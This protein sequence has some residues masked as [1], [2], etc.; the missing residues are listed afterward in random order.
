M[1]AGINN[2]ALFGLPLIHSPLV[3]VLYIGDIGLALL[4]QVC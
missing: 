3:V 4:L 1:T 2:L